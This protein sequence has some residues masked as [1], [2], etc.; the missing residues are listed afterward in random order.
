MIKF[1]EQCAFLTK[2]RL[3]STIRQRGH[4]AA[5]PAITHLLAYDYATALDKVFDLTAKTVKPQ[6]ILFHGLMLNTS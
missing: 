5:V 6:V 4:K 2:E 1:A 3:A